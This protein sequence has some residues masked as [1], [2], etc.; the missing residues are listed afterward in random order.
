MRD[1]IVFINQSFGSLMIDIANGFVGSYRQIDVIA[2]KVA[3]LHAELHPSIRVH[4]IVQYN[5]KNL[6]ARLWT[7]VVGSLQILL[8]IW[9]RFRGAELFLVT[10]PPF[11][12]FIPLVI[13]NPYSF[14]IFD[15]YPDVLVSHR[16]LGERS[17]FVRLW[18]RVNVRVLGRAR[19]VFTISQGMAGTLLNYCGKESIVV[20]PNWAN[21][22][23]LR[24]IPKGE[25]GF[26][27]QH[28]L[29]GEFVVLYSGNMGATHHCE[30]IVE[31]AREMRGDLGV[32]FVMIGDGAGRR[33]VERR[34]ELYQLTNCRVLPYQ[35]KERVPYSL[36]AAD[37]GIVTLNSETSLYSVPSK[38]YSLLAVGVPLLAIAEPESELSSLVA[39]FQVG[40]C[41]RSTELISMRDFILS[42]YRNKELHGAYQRNARQASGRFTPKNAE[43]YRDSLMR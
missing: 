20:V 1:R 30:L 18:K 3:P 31:L 25:N 43:I 11:T 16:Y 21:T 38:T 34:I 5:N 2:G 9:T 35:S 14:L 17:V 7:W 33:E 13:R 23:Y 19:R 12:S 22:A 8:M 28:Q 41:F 40:A 42:N 36:G 32:V 29:E 37:I 15:I 24:P 27:Q 6:L 39:R 4:S 26:I 10:N